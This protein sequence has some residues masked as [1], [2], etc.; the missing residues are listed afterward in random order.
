VKKVLFEVQN[1]PKL[2]EA[3]YRRKKSMSVRQ[4]KSSTRK[5]S[6]KIKGWHDI[7]LFMV[8]YR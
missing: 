2:E 6:E 5:T 8:L 7:W 3:G 4:R 1:Q